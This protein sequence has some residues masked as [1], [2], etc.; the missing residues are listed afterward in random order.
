[1]FCWVLS[2]V[3]RNSHRNHQIQNRKTEKVSETSIMPFG[4]A[5]EKEC[6]QASRTNLLLWLVAKDVA[7]L[8][9]ANLE[10]DD[11]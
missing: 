3:Y 10:H 1:M 2:R 7:I 9:T 4:L 11:I 6:C 8:G 5:W